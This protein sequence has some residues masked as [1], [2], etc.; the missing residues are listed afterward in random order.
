MCLGDSVVKHVNKLNFL[1]FFFFNKI[2]YGEREKVTFFARSDRILF[3]KRV[4]MAL[5]SAKSKQM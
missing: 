1:F 3:Q 5:L 2:N 4:S